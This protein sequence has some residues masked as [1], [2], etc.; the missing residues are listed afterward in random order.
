M[1]ALAAGKHVLSEKPYSRRSYEVVEA[2]DAAKRAGLVLMEGFIR[3]HSPRTRRLMEL[4]PE[5]GQLQT[6]RATFGFR[7]EDDADNRLRP[8]LEGDC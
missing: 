6:I 2:F 8:D 1:K 5:I 3:R 4:L 7:I